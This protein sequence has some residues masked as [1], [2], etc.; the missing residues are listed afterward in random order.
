M[1]TEA[2]KKTTRENHLIDMS[3]W[4][5]AILIFDGFCRMRLI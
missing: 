2:H 3:Q 4:K 1:D 5:M